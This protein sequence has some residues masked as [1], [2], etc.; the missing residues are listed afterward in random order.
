M[1]IC[2]DY[3]VKNNREMTV[4]NEID[5]I[6]NDLRVFNYSSGARVAIVNITHL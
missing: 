3:I 1:I 4:K 2:Y 5:L 6:L